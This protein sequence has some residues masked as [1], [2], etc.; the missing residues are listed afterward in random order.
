MALQTCEAHLN[1][2]VW[3]VC[4]R[5]PGAVTQHSC[6]NSHYTSAFNHNQQC[7]SLLVCF[8]LIQQVYTSLTFHI[9]ILHEKMLCLWLSTARMTE[10]S[11]SDSNR[12]LGGGGFKLLLGDEGLLVFPQNYGP[13]VKGNWWMDTVKYVSIWGCRY[14]TVVTPSVAAVILVMDS[15]H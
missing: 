2:Q 15:R 12:L 1:V 10:V 4:E 14:W 5:Y 3:G 8:F 7:F 13:S 6:I 9:L 11:L